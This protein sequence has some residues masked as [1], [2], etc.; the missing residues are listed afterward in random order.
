MGLV[1]FLVCLFASGIGSICGIGGGV[2][3]KPV[4]DMQGIMSV[5]EASFLSGLTVMSM[6]M[7]N[8]IMRRKTKL[9]DMRIGSLLALGSIAGGVCGNYLF[10]LVRS[11]SGADSLLGMVQAIALGLITVATLLYTVRFRRC[12]PSYRIHKPAAV[13]SIGAL[14]GICSAFLGIGGGPINIAVLNLAFSMDTKK[15]AATSLYII[16]FSQLSNLASSAIKGTIPQ[17]VPVQLLLMVSAGILGGVIGGAIS[18]KISSE[19]TNKL[20]AVFLTLVIIICIYNAWRFGGDII[21][22][23]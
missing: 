23:R 13:T 5:N 20:L 15:A 17:F 18:K 3:I 14:L 4:I 7:V 9:L 12:L 10:T 6:A 2:I 22:R 16:A 1:L 11:G 8:I 21:C 19:T